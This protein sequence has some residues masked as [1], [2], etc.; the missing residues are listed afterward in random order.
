MIIE[1]QGDYYHGNPLYYDNEDLNEMQK[2]ARLKD[3]IKKEYYDSL[4]YNSLFLWETDINNDLNDIENI[5]LDLC[6]RAV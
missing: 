3:S 2:V 6:K 4:N 5:I 1:C